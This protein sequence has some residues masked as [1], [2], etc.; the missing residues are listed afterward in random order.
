MRDPYGLAPGC[1]FGDHRSKAEGNP[2]KK[3]APHGRRFIEL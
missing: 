2:H 1:G 3:T